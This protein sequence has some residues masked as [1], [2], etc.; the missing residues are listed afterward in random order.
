M[1]KLSKQQIIILAVMV[2]AI[3]YGLYDFLGPKPKKTGA[4]S[5]AARSAELTSF[6]NEFTVAVAKD[7]PGKLDAYSAGRAEAKWGGNPFSDRKLYASWKSA[8]A[9]VAPAASLPK[10]VFTYTGYVEGET[11]KIAI[12][13]DTEYGTGDA[14]DIQ[15]YVVQDILPTK[16]ILLNKKEK[17]TINVPMQEQ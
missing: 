2:I 3:L 12:I 15:G 16:V 7:M 14:L 5:P 17:K 9:P 10:P 13:N 11:K 8:K 1:K 4:L 6:V